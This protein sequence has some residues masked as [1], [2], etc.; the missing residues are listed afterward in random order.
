MAC[1]R[2]F[3]S[4][5]LVS[6]RPDKM[7]IWEKAAPPAGL[8]YLPRWDDSPP[9]VVSPTR[10]EFTISCKRSAEFCKE[11]SE[12]VAGSGVTWKKG[13]LRYP[14]LRKWSI[15]SRRHR[16]PKENLNHLNLGFFC[17]NAQSLYKGLT[18]AL[19]IIITIIMVIIILRTI[20]LSTIS[21]ILTSSLPLPCSFLHVPIV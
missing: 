20:I 14:R 16:V 8:P 3:Y 5:C 13:C 1:A 21:F 17:Q 18:Y 7:F 4:S 2:I 11:I 19:T 15:I 12:K 6:G 9:Q 10:D